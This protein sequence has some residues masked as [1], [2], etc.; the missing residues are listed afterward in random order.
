ME[1]TL[2]SPTVSMKLQRSAEQAKR[3]PA[4]V[5]NKVCHLIDR[6]CLREAY[7]Q[8]QKS[9]APGMDQVTAKQYAENLDENLRDLHERLRDNRYGALPVERAWIEKD[10]G[11]KRPIG[12]PCFEDKI[13]Q[14]AVGMIR[15]AIFEPDFHAFSHG[16]R[17]GHSPH[18]AL[19][20]LREQ[21]RTLHSNWI[22]DADVSGVFDNLDW[23]YLREFS[24]QR[25]NDGRI[26]R[27]I[28]KWLHAGVL[29]A[30]ALIHPDKGTP[31]GGVITLPTKLPPC[32]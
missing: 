2:G 15:E 11:K 5:F 12:K 14:R 31:Q 3:S 17:K 19:H 23:S 26:R 20:E 7:H 25:V 10:D 29:E 22:V 21:C 24:Q 28:G 16:F 30:G 13:V 9:S 8:T 4:M 6:D 18:Q 1:E 32:W 27:L